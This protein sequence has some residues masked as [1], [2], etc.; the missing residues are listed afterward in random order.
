MSEVSEIS[1]APDT[2]DAFGM[3]VVG[4]VPNASDTPGVSCTP[5]GAPDTSFGATGILCA[6]SEASAEA[7]SDRCFITFWLHDGQYA[8][9][10]GISVPQLGQIITTP[11]GILSRN[12]LTRKCFK[13]KVTP[14]EWSTLKTFNRS[15][16]YKNSYL[17]T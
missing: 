16:P 3:S 7:S 14:W 9:P 12:N 4:D 1:K 6:S 10:S 5:F 13:V 17:Q 8:I 2:A 11:V 15:K